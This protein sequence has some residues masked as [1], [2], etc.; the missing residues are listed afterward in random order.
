M[1]RLNWFS[2]WCK[3]KPWYTKVVHNKI[4]WKAL[5]AC[6]RWSSTL[7]YMRTKWKIIDFSRSIE[8][9]E[10]LI[11]SLWRSTGQNCEISIS[12]IKSWYLIIVFFLCNWV[13]IN[14]WRTLPHHGCPF[15]CIQSRKKRKKRLMIHRRCVAA[16][17]S[18]Q[19]IS[20]WPYWKQAL[21]EISLMTN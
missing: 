10:F 16:A 5:E 19:S 4:W 9:Y 21:Q 17:N 18:A 2:S 15:L 11:T 13:I 7:A 12:M 20:K 3:R 8:E 6:N 14:L 1:T